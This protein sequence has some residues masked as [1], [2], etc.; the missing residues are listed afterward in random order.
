MR[1][2]RTS[3]IKATLAGLALCLPWLFAALGACSNTYYVAGSS[4][5]TITGYLEIAPYVAGKRERP[6]VVHTEKETFPITVHMPRSWYHRRTLLKHANKRVVV[7]GRWAHYGNYPWGQSTTYFKISSMELAPGE[8]PHREVPGAVPPP[9]VV[10]SRRDI[11]NLPG[12]WGVA[13]GTT[14]YLA[15]TPRRGPAAPPLVTRVALRLQDGFTISMRLHSG[16]PVVTRDGVPG[17]ILL[18]VYKRP[19]ARSSTCA[20]DSAKVIAP[21]RF[22]PSADRQCG[23]DGRYYEGRGLTEP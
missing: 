7:T 14:K 18:T 16:Q 3:R 9:P 2:S 23:M 19:C 1:T 21:R 8:K 10:R 13:V 20:D 12:A 6:A 5:Q 17:S 22:C 4:N 11:D 15:T